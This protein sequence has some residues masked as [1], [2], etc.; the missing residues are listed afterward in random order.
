MTVFST[1]TTTDF[2]ILFDTTTPILVIRRP[3]GLVSFVSALFAIVA[4]LSQLL[5][6]LLQLALA[7]DRLD[8]RDVAAHVPCLR[9]PFHRAGG[10]LETELVL[11]LDQ[12]PLQR[13]ELGIALVLQ[14]HALAHAPISI[15]SRVTNRVLIG[16][17]CA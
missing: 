2:S 14:N 17:L 12:V 10:L 13:Q 8:A 6:G 7:E 15:S 11:L 9:R 4:S 3:A 5:R 1:D 16:S